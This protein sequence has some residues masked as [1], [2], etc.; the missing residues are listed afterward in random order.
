MK[1]AYRHD[2]SGW[3]ERTI[4]VM[5]ALN[6]ASHVTRQQYHNEMADE[7]VTRAQRSL[8]RV[9]RHEGPLSVQG[10]A[11]HMGL[12]NST[13][14]GII[15]RLEAKGYVERERLAEDRRTVSVRISEKYANQISD[16]Y[17]LMDKR[18]DDFVKSLSEEEICTVCD[19]LE[20]YM[21]FMEKGK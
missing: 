19:V 5:R 9:L 16:S 8:M 17:S 15:D 1:W 13:V 3:D 6:S 18:I 2:T 14:S 10:L 21:E 7:E 11:K 20:K 12:S 4:K